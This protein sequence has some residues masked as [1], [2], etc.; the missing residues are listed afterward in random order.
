MNC[1]DDALFHGDYFQDNGSMWEKAFFEKPKAEVSEGETT[2]AA[3]SF[4][5]G[6]QKK[7]KMY[8]LREIKTRR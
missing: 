2:M 3:A 6:W 4:Q 5:R 1:I 7:K 8:L